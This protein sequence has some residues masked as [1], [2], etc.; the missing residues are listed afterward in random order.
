MRRM[1]PMA[2][3]FALGALAGGGAMAL[4]ERQPLAAT[5]VPAPRVHPTTPL[6]CAAVEPQ[7]APEDDMRLEFCLSQLQALR[8][9][10]RKVRIPWP[11]DRSAWDGERPT[12]WNA[13]M[14]R[15]LQG[16]DL[17]GDLVVTDCSEPPCVAAFRATEAAEMEGA[18]SD[19][20]EFQDAF[21]DPEVEPTPLAVPCGDGRWETMVLLTTFTVEQRREYFTAVGLQEA[22][23]DE[24]LSAF[25]EGYR[26]LSR[27]GDGLVGMFDC[28]PPVEP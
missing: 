6:V 13:H 26:I 24:R 17:P 5:V 20:A 12:E 14:D 2:I 1:V 23:D 4:V 9:D 27:R 16:C 18:L 8:A 21:P 28:D 10:Q 7:E 19:C 11:E 15:V 22:M 3:G 25:I